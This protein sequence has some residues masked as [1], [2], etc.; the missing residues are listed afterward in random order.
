M[1]FTTEK[2]VKNIQTILRN[3]IVNLL[4]FDNAN[5]HNPY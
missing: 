5:K 4:K 3:Q 1:K 2:N